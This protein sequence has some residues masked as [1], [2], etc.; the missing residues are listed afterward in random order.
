MYNK[1]IRASKK[2]YFEKELQKSIKDPKKTWDILKEAIN[3][4]KPLSNVDRITVN[5]TK[6][7]DNKTMANEFNKFF[8]NI[9]VQISESVPPT[10]IQPE[11]YLTP[12]MNTPNLNLNGIGPNQVVDI[13]K[14]LSPKKSLDIDGISTY[15]ISKIAHEVSVPLAHIFSLSI[16]EGIFPDRLKTSRTVP[17]FKAGNPELC[18]NYRPIAL[19]SSLSKILEKIVSIQLVNHLDINKLIYKHQY[20]FQQNKST[21]HNLIHAVNYIG[22]AFNEGKY[23][24]GV[25]FDLKKAFDVCSHSILLKKLKNLGIKG[26]ELKWFSSYLTDRKQ[27]VDINGTLS[28]SNEIK[29]S[30]LQGSILGPI[31]FLCYI[32]DLHTVTDLLMLMFADDTFCVKSDT[33]LDRL[34]QY[35]NGEINKM[36]VWFRANKLAVNVNKT[37]FMIFRSVG[38]KVNNNISDLIY[39]ENEPNKPINP[40]LITRL[41]RYHNNHENKDCRAYKLLGIYFDEHLTL[42]FHVNNL[43]KKLTR[44]MYCIRQAKNLLNTRSL[45]SLYYA[46]VHSHLTYC[47][48]IVGITNNKNIKQITVIQKKAIRVISKSK[49]NEHTNPIF[50]SLRILPYDKIILQNKLHFMHSIEYDYAPRSFTGTWEKNVNRHLNHDLRNNE[51]YNLPN[52]RLELFRKIPLYSIP[53]EWNNLGNLI[54]HQNKNLFRTLLKEKLFNDI[55]D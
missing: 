34:I 22:E 48:S 54:Y 8:T 27:C 20:G 30:I 7:T 24:V 47:P 36:A 41:E 53:Y 35:V 2:L 52:V 16:Q 26:M 11:D 55:E 5:D 15:L 9:G 14:L 49:Y 13:I 21:E 25:F 6:I 19:L 40:Q 10:E 45:K 44:S 23:A 17:I 39:D 50:K 32:N 33:D 4:N 51:L 3:I 46:L 42:N 29:I 43:C 28:D 18:D 1:I 12:M 38:K 31:L 37:K